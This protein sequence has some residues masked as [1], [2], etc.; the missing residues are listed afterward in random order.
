MGLDVQTGADAVAPTPP[1]RAAIVS[2]LRAYAPVVVA[3]V[4]L[5]LLPLAFGGSGYYR[6][7][8]IIMLVYAAYAIAFNI[9]FGGTGQLF[10]CLGALGGLSAY[11]SVV[12]TQDGGL[13]LLVTVPLG[14]LLAAALGALFSWVA[15]RRNLDVIFIG[16]V[17]L[18]FSLVF[19]NMVQG[20]RSLTGG[21][22]GMVVTG[23]TGTP[24]RGAVSYYVFVALLVAFLA[25]YQLIDRSHLGWAFRALK[26]DELAAELAGI[27]V[28]RYRI[29]AGAIGAAMVGLT[30][31]L[32]VHHEGFISPSV[33][34]FAHLDVRVLV[35]LAFGGIGSLLG[36]I[37]GAAAVSVLDEFL[38]PL[39]Q[40]RL[41][42]YGVVL[43]TL[44]LF[45]RQGVVPTLAAATHRVR[46]RVR[47]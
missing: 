22:T 20:L 26:N 4:V 34:N 40:L 9:I 44:F 10:L 46:D 36:P 29:M 47:R 15:V 31:A 27:D 7:L 24:L 16:I 45:F 23:G 32:Y 2:P 5:A 17:T 3:A 18:A 33:F 13:P 30:G 1:E 11:V 37:V 25:L 19:Y 39:G 38:R 28:A 35:V 42:V 12:L 6:T 41:A 43:M 21:E 14:T 8:A